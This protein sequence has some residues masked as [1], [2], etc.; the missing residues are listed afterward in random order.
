MAESEY[1]AFG[2]GHSST[3]ISAALGMAIASSIKGENNRQHIAVIGDGSMT[4]GMAFEAMNHAGVSKSNLLVV[5]ND[6]GIAIDKNVGALKEYLI[7]ITTSRF[8]NRLKGNIW[9]IV[10]GKTMRRMINKFLL[11]LK[12][13]IVKQSNLFESLNF[14]YFGPVDGHDVIRLVK[15]F[16]DLKH[17]QGPKIIH[18]ITVKGKGFKHAENE[19]TRFHA[20]GMFDRETG[21]AKELICQDASPKYQTVFGKTLVELADKNKLIVGITPAMLSGCSMSIMMAKYPNRTFD[22][23]IA[24]Q[25]A[26]TFSAGLAVQGLIPFCN[27]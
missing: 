11:N 8:Y 17:L 2:V 16:N 15:I 26:V 27:K 21:K 20:P 23:G 12:S 1:D 3:S 13:A 19:Q 10:R 24:E 9:N 5:L 25:H 7:D 14:R 18:C 22:V 6:N 4:A